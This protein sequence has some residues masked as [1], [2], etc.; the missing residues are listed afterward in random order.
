MNKAISNTHQVLITDLR[1]AETKLELARKDRERIELLL[2][3][4]RSREKEAERQLA[5]IVDRI[6][7]LP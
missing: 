7:D 6:E 4:A 3:E 2:A 1:V 5:D